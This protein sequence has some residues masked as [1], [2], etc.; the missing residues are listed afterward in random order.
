MK[1]IQD[2]A[3]GIYPTEAEIREGLAQL[4]D[5]QTRGICKGTT[6]EICNG[7]IGSWKVLQNGATI[8]HCPPVTIG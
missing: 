5:A 3:K 2:C 6:F 1:T 7:S 8:F 4:R